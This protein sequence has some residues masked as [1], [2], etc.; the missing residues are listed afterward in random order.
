MHNLEA[1][2]SMLEQTSARTVA[3]L[4]KTILD[5]RP[6]FLEIWR[7]YGV[8]KQLTPPPPEVMHKRL[9]ICIGIDWG[10][11]GGLLNRVVAKTL[12]TQK[13][14]EAD[15][16]I[17]GKMAHSHFKRG[18]ETTIHY[19]S[20]PKHVTLKNIQPLYKVIAEYAHI[21]IVYPS[22]E[23]IGRQTVMVAS[24]SV[25]DEID[26]QQATLDSQSNVTTTITPD[27]FIVDPS[28][29]VLSNYLNETVIGLTFYHYFLESVL[30]Y[31]AAQMIAMR[32]SHDN[33]KNEGEKLVIRYNRARREM[34]DQ[35]IRELYGSRAAHK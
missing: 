29:Q 11:S 15:L 31:N 23:S 8:L 28:P 19:F 22:F 18:I 21:T 2:T 4:R 13:E 12:E 26:K 3:Q 35:K 5:S 30:A 6:F 7:I 27:R 17:A 1:L 25:I 24:I 20:A 34:V 32:N 10:M 33:A 16:L 14:Q 9:V